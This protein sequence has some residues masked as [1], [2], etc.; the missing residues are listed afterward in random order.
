LSTEEF[1]RAF[2]QYL[3]LGFRQSW[4]ALVRSRSCEAYGVTLVWIDNELRRL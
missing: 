2:N 1:T 4:E 3:W